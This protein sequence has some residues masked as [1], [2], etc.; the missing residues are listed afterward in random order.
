MA[1]ENPVMLA[2]V[3]ALTAAVF[4]LGL[5]LLRRRPPAVSPPD[6]TLGLLQQQVSRLVEQINQLGA[7][8]PRDVGTSLSQLTGQMATRLSENAQALQ[9]AS[10]DTGRLI[11]DINLRLGELRQSSQEI[12]ALGQDVRGLQQIFQAPKIRGGLGEMSLGSILQ[13]VFPAAHFALQHAF[14]DGLIVDAV[15]RLP[16]G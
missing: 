2:V 3:V 13:Q 12:L 4:G 6:P 1:I 15:L 14:R 7:Q 10:A 16:G 9:K 11:A 8:I 5:A